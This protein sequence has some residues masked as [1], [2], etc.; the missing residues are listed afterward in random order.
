LGHE[1]GAAPSRRR[2]KHRWLVGLGIAAA[3]P[4][5]AA[6]AYRGYLERKPDPE[7]GE[8]ISAPMG[9]NGA[10]VTGFDGVR[11]YTE[12]LGDGDTLVLIP[13]WFSNTTHWHYQKKEL[14]S[15]YRIVSYDQRGHRWSGFDDEKPI[16]L[17]TLARDLKSVLD[18]KAPDGPVVLVGHSLGGMAILKF[19]ECFP[20][21]LGARVKGVALVD[22][23]NEPVQSCAAGGRAIVA[24]KEPVVE[25]LFRWAVRHPELTEPIKHSFIQTS[26]F[27]AATRFFGYGSSESLTQLEYTRDMAD[28]TSMKGAC[29][30]GLGILESERAISLDPLAECRIPV[31][32]W[33]GEK[34]LLTKCAVSR[35]MAE[36]LPGC[37]LRVVEDTGH[38]SFMEAYR[39]FNSAIH[40]L[41]QRS[42]AP[43]R[44]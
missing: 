17:E 29:L 27:L 40:D 42:F 7:A 10:F 26:V 35:R 21:E 14:S 34:D 25:P 9:E 43:R 30:A 24:L 18:A 3:V 12:E 31:L 38:P 16:T 11:L 4:L 5:V 6:R 44:G 36:A 8:E 33:V 23:S 19:T 28:A 2:V 20:E 13:G 1:E 37:E 41:A 22:T 39:D 32:I 15:D